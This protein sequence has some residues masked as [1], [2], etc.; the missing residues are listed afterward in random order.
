MLLQETACPTCRAGL[1]IR[2]ECVGCMLRVG[3]A[4]A[5]DPHLLMDVPR[6]FGDFQI[7]CHEDGSFWELGRGAMGVTYRATDQVLHRTVALKVIATPEGLSGSTIVRERFLREARVAAGL[8]HPNVAEVF[9]FGTAPQ[10]DHAY[11]AMEMIDGETL[12]ARVR[13]DGPL[14]VEI[15]LEIASQVVKALVA[16]ADRGLV[17]RDLKPSNIMLSGKSS[18]GALR[19]KVIDFGLAKAVVGV[20]DEMHLTH[21]GFLGTPAF[22]SP[23]QFRGESADAR[24]DIYSLGATLWYALTGSTPF[25]GK[26][27]EELRDHPARAALPIAQLAA[28]KVP[29]RVVALLRSVLAVDPAARPASAREL[30][31]ALERCRQRKTR[32]LAMS[33]FVVGA[34]LILGLCWQANLWRARP[35]L[36]MGRSI[37]APMAADR[38][39]YELYARA[40]AIHI[41]DN[42]NGVERSLHERL[43]LLE[44]ATHH[45]PKFALAYCELAKAEAALSDQ[46]AARKALDQASNLHAPP[47]DYHLAR[48]SVYL[49][50]GDFDHARG[51]ATIAL[52]AS[53][54]E[55]EALR[56]LSNADTA[57]ERWNEGLAEMEKAYE[58]DPA[59]YEIEW[60]LGQIY[61]AMRRYKERERLLDINRTMYPLNSYW[62]AIAYVALKLDQ[63]DPTGAREIL[64]QI[65]PEFSPISGV[66][67]ERFATA[68]FLRD[69]DEAERVMAATPSQWRAGMYTGD[70]PQSWMDGIIAHLRG[71][72]PKARAIFTALRQRTTGMPGDG[73]DPELISLC[74]AFLGRKDDAIREARELCAN[75]PLAKLAEQPEPV[76]NHILNLARVYALTGERD[77]AIDELETLAKLYDTISY[78][79]VR[80]GHYWDAL[81]GEP[82]FEA[83]VASLAP[84]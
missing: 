49:A 57:Q 83:V 72:Q 42:P 82:R 78:G 81:R 51:E 22:A 54:N 84:K 76:K 5:S 23:E 55:A 77:Q 34:F 46:P 41:Y 21:G 68:M 59:N 62:R 27:L 29:A 69:Y 56:I 52:N 44:E 75:Y 36:G 45:D 73:L 65:P 37:S 19:A 10:T 8:H 71:D 30:S 48:A 16:A 33:T 43:S 12:E 58:L 6:V 3:L 7:E 2:G 38:K 15:A 66:W 17:H 39:A 24:S 28:R 11:Y 60:Q 26:T 79:D 80:C 53:P 64:K 40:K 70:P 20:E 61:Q 63:G 13:R 14:R 35:A 1:N 4:A 74:D 67:V 25:A 47:R 9:R 31:D 32:P 18:S 50:A